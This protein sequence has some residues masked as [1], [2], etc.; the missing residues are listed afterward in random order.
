MYRILTVIKSFFR[1]FV[2]VDNQVDHKYEIVSVDENHSDS[3]QIYVKLRMLGR[4]VILSRPVSELYSK[5]WLKDFSKEDAAYIAV[6]YLSQSK[7]NLDIVKLFPRKKQLVTKNV[8]FLGMLFVTFLI[9]SNLTAFKVVDFHLVHAS[10]FQHILPRDTIF[11][12]ALIFFPL[13]YFFDDALTEVYGFKISRFVIW[14]GLMCNTI[15]TLCVLV[16]VY[17][18]ASPY[19]HYQHAYS[20][21]FTSVPRVFLASSLGYFFG[22]FLNSTLISRLKVLTKGRW[23]WARIL[24]STSLGVMVDSV[25]FCYTA[26]FGLLPLSMISDMVLVQVLF[27]ISYEILVLPFTYLIIGFLKKRDNVDYYD[28]ATTYNPFSLTIE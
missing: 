13:T 24:S 16:T 14:M 5:N 10:L 18:P 9:V 27:K 2:F 26:F 25:I 22:E 7:N 17:L 21:I 28:Y 3:K 19:W 6:L 1:S 23:L 15:F 4:R 8:I 12:A 20:L 11:P